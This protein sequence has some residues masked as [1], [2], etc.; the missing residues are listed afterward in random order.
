L[1][2]LSTDG[3]HEAKVTQE[4]NKV[5]VQIGPVTVNFTGKC[6]GEIVAGGKKTPLA[7]KV[8]KGDWE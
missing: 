7:E 6:G 1:H 3:L 4:G 2:V 8:E 5:S